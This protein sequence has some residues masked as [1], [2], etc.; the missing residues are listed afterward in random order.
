MEIEIIKYL[1]L[2]SSQ[3][4]IDLAIVISNIF[5]WICFP[6]FFSVYYNFFKPRLALLFA[7]A[8]LSTM[9]LVAILK[10][11][12]NRPRPFLVSNHIKNL[13]P[14]INSSFPSGHTAC[15]SVCFVF[16]II[17]INK[18]KINNIIKCIF[19]ILNILFLLLLIVSRQLLGQHFLSD[20]ITS[21]FIGILFS[22]LIVMI[23]NNKKVNKYECK[24]NCRK[25]IK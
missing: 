14:A 19:H 7:G 9:S 3:F 23:Y 20:I 18:L 25:K 17:F 21:L 8:M 6:L 12:I 10:F 2:H 4:V 22:F 13:Y 24:R 15:C 16:N 1:Q 5:T 11:I